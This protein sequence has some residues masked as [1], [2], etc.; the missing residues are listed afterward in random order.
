MK[1]TVSIVKVD[2]RPYRAIAQENWG[3]TDAQMKGRHV[4]HRIHRSD[5]GTNDPSNLYVCT[6]MFHDLV[7]HGDTGGFIG[8]ATEGGKK[9]GASNV[10]NKTGFCGRTPEKM[11]ADGKKGGETNVANRT[12]FLSPEWQESK[13]RREG[14]VKNGIRAKEDKSGIHSEEWLS[15]EDAKESRARGGKT[16]GDKCVKDGTGIMSSEW[17]ESEQYLKHQS[18]AGQRGGEKAAEVHREN[19]T[20]IF[21][22]TSEQ[23][24]ENSRKANSQVW[25]S[26]HDGFR[27]NAGNVARHNKANGWD[28]A[29]RVK[30]K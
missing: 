13:E 5:G 30:V 12:G 6:P 26:T 16:Q 10:V 14:N 3:L 27:A 8:L 23:L 1:K 22:L 7:W 29:D 15:S 17:R 4:H 11:S 20:G 19:K 24:S 25:E 18:K 21:G 2:T 28:P 9:G